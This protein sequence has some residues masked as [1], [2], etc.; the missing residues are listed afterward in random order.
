MKKVSFEQ[1]LRN[2]FSLYGTLDG[3][4]GVSK[5]VLSYDSGFLEE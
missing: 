1:D 3:G 5:A 2:D 4:D